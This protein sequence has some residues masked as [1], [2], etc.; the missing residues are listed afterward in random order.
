MHGY[1]FRS[2]AQKRIE[3][4][5]QGSGDLFDLRGAHEPH[6]PPGDPADRV[7]APARLF[8][9]ARPTD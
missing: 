1:L 6:L 3:A 5:L 4:F 2:G 8:A 9:L 7:L